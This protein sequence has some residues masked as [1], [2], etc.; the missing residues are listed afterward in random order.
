MKFDKG[1]RVQIKAGNT[2]A[3]VCGEVFWKGAKKWGS[4]DRLGV[5]GD[6]GQTYWIDEVAV[7]QA[8]KQAPTDPGVTFSKGD[9]VS[10]GDVI[11]DG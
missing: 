1:D 10:K 11:A 2:G 5:R 3:G 4:G 6:D 8:T 9:R 7:E